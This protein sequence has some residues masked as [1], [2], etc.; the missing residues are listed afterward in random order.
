VKRSQLATILWLRWR[1]TRNQWAK[2]RGSGAVVALLMGIRDVVLAAVGLLGGLAV[3]DLALH[4]AS[5]T[6]VMLTWLG[7]TVMFF[8]AWAIGVLTE[9]QRSELVDLPRLMHLP[10]ALGQAFAINYVASLMGAT[11][12]AFVPAM[13]GLSVGLAL[14]R[15]PSMLLCA[16]LSLGLLFMVTAW[17]YLFQGWLATWVQNPRRRRVLVTGIALTVVLLVQ[18]PNLVFNVFGSHTPPA[19]SRAARAAEKAHYALLLDRLLLAEKIVPP[20]WLPAGAGRLA[21]GDP[22]VA[23]LGTAAFAA[24][25]A[26]ALRRGYR[27][28][29]RFYT[30]GEGGGSGGSARAAP[31]KVRA[32]SARRGRRLVERGIPGVPDQ[33]AALAVATLRS[34]LRAP[35]IAM[36]MGTS[37][38]MMLIM[39]GGVLYRVRVGPHVQPLLV[40]TVM[41]VSN[42][43][44]AGFSGNL[45]G[46]DRDGLRMLLLAP[47]ARQRL[48]LGKNLAMLSLG[49]VPCTV[50]LVGSSVWLGLPPLAVLAGALQMASFL[51]VGSMVGNL[52][53]ILLPF[54]V[55]SGAMKAA[56]PPA[57]AVLATLGVVF[58]FP[59]LC[60]PAY[61]GPALVL[62]GH[63]AGWR[64][65]VLVDLAVSLAMA[66]AAAGAYAAAL[67]PLGRLLQRRETLIL[68]RVTVEQ[69]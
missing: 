53:S 52:Q 25:G 7:V 60:F 64:H 28:T 57:G 34:M 66:A 33:A 2:S 6:V 9:L 27:S 18:V 23:L 69:E 22:L 12:A 29:L 58:F 43:A 21:E 68:A 55:Q 37:L 17:T 44:V 19:A 13:L 51:L 65:P 47:I 42:L 38:V 39:S 8:F 14:D 36:G 45:F 10:I 15:G 41:L 67:A 20:L 5:A 1:L 11:L 4:D 54:R 62:V 24:L 63:Y 3:G 46:H 32:A 49:A 61:A 16:P 48:L 35:E 50:V 56:K 31:V 40:V 59:V 30:G 26:L